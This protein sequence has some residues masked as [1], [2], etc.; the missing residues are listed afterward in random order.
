MYLHCVRQLPHAML[1]SGAVG[2]NLGSQMLCLSQKV[3][4]IM[5]DILLGPKCL[6]SSYYVGAWIYEVWNQAADSHSNP[7]NP[8]PGTANP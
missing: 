4:G 5:W 7:L 6:F 8:G 1:R 3:Q 2:L